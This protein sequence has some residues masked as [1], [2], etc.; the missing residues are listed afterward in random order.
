LATTRTN[1]I[2]EKLT[3]NGR[4]EVATLASELGVSQV[5]IRRDLA[6]LENR[7]IVVREHGYATLKSVDDVRG[8]IAYH[9]EAKRAIAQAAAALVANGDALMIENGSCCALLAEE[10][11][12]TK[13]DLT[14]ITNS[15]FIVDYLREA[16][17]VELMLLGGIYQPE[18]QVLVGPMVRTCVAGLCPRRFFIGVDGFS[19]THG[20]THRDALRA[21]AVRDMA[22]QAQ[23][24]IVLTQSEKFEKSG[25]IPLALE[26]GVTRVITDVSLSAAAREALT[27]QG[28]AITLAEEPAR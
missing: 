16:T 12:A 9:Y 25:L 14:I 6:E 28:V 10:L 13:E 1:A 24:V 23:E 4:V 22:A 19:P 3:Q 26:H 21:Q 17:G 7:G 15:A 5:T 18:S 11:A 8:R 2:L 20:F 27:A